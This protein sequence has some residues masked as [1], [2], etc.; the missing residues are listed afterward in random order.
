MTSASDLDVL[1]SFPRAECER[2]D[3]YGGNGQSRL[4][5]A[6]KAAVSA[7]YPRTSIRA[8]GQV[9]VVDISDGVK[10]ELL[11]A[12][13]RS[14]WSGEDFDYPD[15]NMGGRWLS[16]N[17]R[18]EQAAMKEKNDASNGLLLDTCKHMR[19]IH[20]K[21]AEIYSSHATKLNVASIAATALTGSG[22]LGLFASDDFVLKLATALLA[23]VSL[24]LYMLTM[25]FDFLGEAASHRHAAKN[26]LALREGGRDLLSELKGE[27][28][29]SE[30]ARACYDMLRGKYSIACSLAPQ[31]GAA[32]VER[33]AT[34][35]K[36]GESTVTQRERE[37][38]AG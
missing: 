34:A 19:K 10:F 1:V 2:Y 26:F 35:L 25:A 29:S 37:Q 13:A 31:T 8:D 17:P 3:A 20:E 21:Q 36:D 4:L 38:M 12:F 7:T 33:A 16:T 11:P 18:A 22:A 15:S 9:V 24:L 32:V 14:S 27:R 30:S 5:Q 28:V 23:F 6:V